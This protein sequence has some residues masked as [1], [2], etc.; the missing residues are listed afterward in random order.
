MILTSGDSLILAIVFLSSKNITVLDVSFNS[1]GVFVKLSS[2]Q[3]SLV[4]GKVSKNVN[5]FCSEPFKNFS[6]SVINGTVF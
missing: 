3:T 4:K 5:F 1:S 6:N 2:V